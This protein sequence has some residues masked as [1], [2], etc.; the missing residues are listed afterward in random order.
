MNIS[1]EKRTRSM[2]SFDWAMKRLLRQKANFQVLE[3]FLSE[4]LRRDIVI[5]NIGEGQ[6]NKTHKDNK[7][8][9]VD[10]L[11]DIKAEHP[12]RV[13][14]TSDTKTGKAKQ[15]NI[16]MKAES[17]TQEE[18]E[19]ET[20]E[21]LLEVLADGKETVIIELQYTD[22]HDYFQRILFGVSKAINDYMFKGFKYHQ[23]RKVYSVSIIYF[24]LGRGDDYVYHGS[25]IFKGMHTNNVLELSPQLKYIYSKNFPSELYPEYYIIKVENFNKVA[26]E[27]LDQWIHY[28]KT[29][30]IKD[31]F[32]AKGMDIAKQILDY[33]KLSPEEKAEHDNAEKVKRIRES[34]VETKYT[35]GFLDGRTE[36][37]AELLAE[38]ETKREQKVIEAHKKGHSIE[39]IAE[40]TDLTPD[41]IAQILKQHG[42]LN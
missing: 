24:D 10:V 22:H 23:V 13:P 34:E 2:V 25:T 14:V 9:D 21:I 7:E 27:T 33:D 32:N 1:E 20:K 31:S 12:I 4:L 16:P 6:G 30:E 28:F 3:G 42:L 26:V 5:T 29:N 35:Y 18:T 37:R 8:N 36:G 39:L 41:Q 38:V 40:F 15:A 17:P 11:V 19:P